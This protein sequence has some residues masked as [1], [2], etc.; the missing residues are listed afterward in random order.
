MEKII[1]TDRVKNEVLYRVKGEMSIIHTIKRRKDDW[2]DHIQSENCILKH[3]IKGKIVAK[4]CVT[5]RR[6]RS[7]KQLQDDLEETRRNW[8]LK[9][10]ALH[11]SLRRTRFG[12]LWTCRKTGY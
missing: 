12:R 10:E 6:G 1:W 9:G 8:S 11:R 7:R 3:D 4:I 5:G 2:D